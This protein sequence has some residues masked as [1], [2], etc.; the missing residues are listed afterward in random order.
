MNSAGKSSL[1]KSIG[2]NIIMAQ[3]GMYVPCER[4]RYYPYK[5]IY[6]RIPGGDDIFK[7]Q[8][9]FVGE[10]SELRNILKSADDRTLV[11]GDELCSGTET[12]SA[13]AIV[14]T[15]ILDLIKKKSSFIFATHLHEL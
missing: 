15:G 14:C 6:S 10:I 5:N 8:S 3:A 1:M 7:G 9:T 2:L 13:I 11:I 4:L 12:N